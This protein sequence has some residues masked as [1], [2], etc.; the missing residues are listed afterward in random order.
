MADSSLWTH[1]GDPRG[2]DR[3][4]PGSL[5]LSH[6]P[7]GAGQLGG[8]RETPIPEI[9]HHPE[10]RYGRRLEHRPAGRPGSAGP[11]AGQDRSVGAGD[12]PYCGMARAGADGLGGLK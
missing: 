6:D 3:A 8:T 7:R 1:Q 9:R 10:D 11:M 5:G 12:Q 4:G 2:P